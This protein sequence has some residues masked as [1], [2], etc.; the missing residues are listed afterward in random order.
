MKLSKQKIAEIWG[1]SP[2]A[3]SKT[4]TGPAAKGN[5]QKTRQWE[6][7][8]MGAYCKEQGITL[9]ELECYVEMRET[10]R[11]PLAE[12]LETKERENKRLAKKV[13]NIEQLLG[14]WK[15]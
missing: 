6:I 15:K 1:I 4:Y 9:E 5:Q 12:K 10:L 2:R 3:L 8:S 11:K 13:E 7:L 14:S